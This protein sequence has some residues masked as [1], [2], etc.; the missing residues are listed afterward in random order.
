M[1]DKRTGAS[2]KSVVKFIQTQKLTPKYKMEV[3]LGND[4]NKTTDYNDGHGITGNN[5]WHEIS[6]IIERH[7]I[8][9]NNERPEITDDNQRLEITY[10]NTAGEWK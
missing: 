3:S 10:N 2:V 6:D 8:T 4:E 9:H 7:E 1:Q 5:G